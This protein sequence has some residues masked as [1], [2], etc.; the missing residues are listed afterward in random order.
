M[1]VMAKWGPKK[2][3]ISNKK[4][5]PI[6]ELSLK[7]AY[8]TDE[9]KKEKREVTLPY[10]VYKEFGVNVDKEISS[11]YK[12]LGK[13]NGLYLGKKRM[14][15]KKLK[16]VDVSVSAIKVTDTGVVRSAEFSLSFA[17]P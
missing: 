5:N 16:L 14:G 4:L 2:W 3:K 13:S 1:A 17:E 9:K 7:M 10:K 15:P 12:L 8:D 11:W 6:E